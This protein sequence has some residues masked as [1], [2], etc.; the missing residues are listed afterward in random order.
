MLLRVAQ[1]V[2]TPVLIKTLLSDLNNF[3]IFLVA[4]LFVQT[5][6]PEYMKQIKVKLF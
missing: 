2:L 6:E 5:T 3:L 1:L 4:E